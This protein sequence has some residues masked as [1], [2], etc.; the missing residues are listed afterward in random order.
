MSVLPPG[1]STPSRPFRPSVQAVQACGPAGAS[2]PCRNIFFLASFMTDTHPSPQHATAPDEAAHG[3]AKGLPDYGDRGFSLFLRRAFI[4]GAGY[5]D[6]ALGR[7]I[8]GIA[9]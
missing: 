5:T 4:K 1:P 3:I 9:N 6:A 2:I 7:P 8:I